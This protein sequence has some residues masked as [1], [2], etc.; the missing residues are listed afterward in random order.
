MSRQIGT[1]GLSTLDGNASS[2]SL[3]LLAARTTHKGKFE[4]RHSGLVLHV[5]I[6]GLHGSLVRA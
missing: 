5:A 4:T 6:A 3:A 2:L 1:V